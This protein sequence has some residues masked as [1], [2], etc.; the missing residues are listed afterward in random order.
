[1]NIYCRGGSETL[2]YARDVIRIFSW[3]LV[4]L[5]AVGV[6]QAQD[7]EASTGWPDRFYA[8]YVY[9]GSLPLAYMQEQTGVRYYT[10]AFMLSRPDK[11]LAAWQG[12]QP[13]A[14]E[15]LILP[16]LEKLR[17]QG[18]D[19]IVSFGGAAGEELAR[20]CTDVENLTA[21][22]QS[23]IDGYNL[24]RLDFDIEGSEIH[25]GDS[26]TRRSQAIAALQARAAAA[27][28]TLDI[29]FTL[30]VLPEGLT[31]EGIAVLQSAIDHSVEI[32]VVNIM[33]MDYGS[34]YPANEMGALSIQAAESLFEQLGTLFP[35]KAETERWQM[36]GLTPMIGLNDTLPQTFTLDDADMLTEFALEKGIRQIAMWS[37]NRD[38]ACGGNAMVLTDSCSGIPQ[39]EFAFSAIFNQV[40]G[41]D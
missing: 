12:G 2:P 22:Y 23:V 39:E 5:V 4:A 38:K 6:I 34:D 7:T 20:I 36:I 19:A 8:P 40:V 32:D 15:K 9:A 3:I 18:G 33:T 29:T 31:E 16:E 37:F 1:M 25:E 30:P 14:S 13:I 41:L 10:L 17:A 26:V 24:T 28:R 35:E 11:C 21:Q 27:G